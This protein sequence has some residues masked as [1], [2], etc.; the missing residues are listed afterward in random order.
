MSS[1][2]PQP[3]FSVIIPTYNRAEKVVRAVQSVLAQTFSDYEIWVVDDGSTDGTEQALSPYLE[4][5]H[6]LPQEN[7]GA[8]AAR[9]TGLQHSTGKYVAFLDSDDWW[10]PQKLQ[11]ISSA[12]HSHPEVGLFY[13]PCEV[14]N[15]EGERLWIDY[16]RSVQ[17]SGYLPLLMGDFLALSSAVVKREC[18][19]RALAFDPAMVP[20]E[21]WDL[22][23]HIARSY[24]IYLVP[25]V[26]VRFEYASNSKLT[27]NTRA[28]LAAH[29]RVVEKI[30]A[31]DPTLSPDM[32][33]SIR[34]NSAYVKGRICLEASDDQEAARWFA[35][36]VKL[37]PGLAKAH[38]Y[39]LL[40][41]MPTIRRW[42]PGKV[43]RRL[44]FPD[45]GGN[46][47]K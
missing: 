14:V 42:M 36:A 12:L 22:W 8:A 28:W 16:S 46:R 38:L 7:C 32:Q 33:R 31:E 5:I 19:A 45:A 4:R 11:A 2:A 6:Y 30:F 27:A 47:A 26:L 35:Q 10:Y 41:S 23:L 34:A 20:C 21:D 18:L 37:S 25:E 43:L 9:N 24:P 3:L 29:D 1:P 13:S 40:C 44:R 17:G 39:R 15:E